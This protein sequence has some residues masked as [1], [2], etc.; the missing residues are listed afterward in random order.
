MAHCKKKKNTKCMTYWPS[1][2]RRR[3]GKRRGGGEEF[4]IKSLRVPGKNSNPRKDIGIQ[5]QVYRTQNSN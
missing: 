3:R 4:Y 1:R 5:I 2:R